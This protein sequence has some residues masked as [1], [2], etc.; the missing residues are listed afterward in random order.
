MTA[1]RAACPS[2]EALETVERHPRALV[3]VLV[4]SVRVREAA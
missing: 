3:D 1:M 4:A 2:E